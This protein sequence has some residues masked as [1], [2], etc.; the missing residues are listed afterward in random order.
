MRGPEKIETV[1]LWPI[2]SLS[3]RSLS[4]IPSLSRICQP[5]TSCGARLPSHHEVF[6]CSQYW[7]H[8][9]SVRY[10]NVCERFLGITAVAIEAS[11]STRH[12]FKNNG[13]PPAG[14]VRSTVD[15]VDNG[16]YRGFWSGSGTAAKAEAVIFWTF[17][18]KSRRS[19]QGAG[20]GLW[21]I[22]FDTTHLI[23]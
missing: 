5:T 12:T 6:S 16:Y 1:Q 10:T 13:V 20:Q 3:S 22:H 14:I 21:L 23:L 11:I 9:S 4:P 8:S 19:H 2:K 18:G 17:G 7:C 15:P